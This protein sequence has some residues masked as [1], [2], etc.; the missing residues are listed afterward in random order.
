M[1]IVKSVS[2]NFKNFRFFWTLAEKKF[3]QHISRHAAQLNGA[4]SISANTLAFP[5]FLYRQYSNI[6]FAL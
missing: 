5:S 2:M 6:P 1:G 3:R 4:L